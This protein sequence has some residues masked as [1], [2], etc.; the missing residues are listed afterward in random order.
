MD[1]DL[2]ALLLWSALALL[3]GIA[4][5]FSIGIV[6]VAIAGAQLVVAVV[7]LRAASTES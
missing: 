3:F 1:R 4:A 2:I 5:I 6:I 7:Y